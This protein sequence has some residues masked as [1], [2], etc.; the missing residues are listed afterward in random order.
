MSEL[1]L[2]KLGGSLIT[3]KTKPLTARPAAIRR[4]CRE[5]K[6]ALDQNELQLILGHGS[7]S[8]GH[9]VAAKYRVQDGLKTKSALQGL[10]LV[11]DA[12]IALN[13][14]VIQELLAQGLPAVSF[15]PLSFLLA[16]NQLP[17][18]VFLSPLLQALNLHLLPVTYGD[19]ILD[20][21]NG[22]TIFSTEKI[23][24]A[25]AVHLQ[26]DQLKIRIIYC[27]D[28]DGVYDPKGQTIPEITPANF[29]NFKQSITGAAATDVT[30]GMLHKVTASLSLAQKLGVNSLIING[31]RK[32]ELTRALLT[33]P[34]SGTLISR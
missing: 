26:A 23:I 10:P 19:V 1:V 31:N 15:A 25:L 30:G 22:F 13:R 7:G 34:T 18:Q 2:I 29:D 8:F 24:D 21:K 27:S 14:L 5:I 6:T 28:T 33:Q 11:A 32:G 12:A 4:L 17:Q 20:S 16:R 9:S 3:D